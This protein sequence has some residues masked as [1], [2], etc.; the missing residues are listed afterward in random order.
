MLI[1]LTSHIFNGNMHDRQETNPTRGTQWG[2][3]NSYETSH[4]KTEMAKTNQTK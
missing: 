3:K 4:N 1:I 2:Q